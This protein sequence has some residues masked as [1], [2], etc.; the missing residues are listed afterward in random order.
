VSVN[1]AITSVLGTE[2]FAE[3]EQNVYEKYQE[4][5]E[6]EIISELNSLLSSILFLKILKQWSAQC[7]CRFLQYREITIRLKSGRQWKVLSRSFP[8]GKAKEKT[9]QITKT[10]KRSPAAFWPRVT[11]DHKTNKSGADRDLRVYGC[12]LSLFRSRRQCFAWSG[13]TYE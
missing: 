4:K 5:A 6:R 2:D 8:P 1:S 3:Y 12:S 9:R 7:A 13:N 11:W 10:A